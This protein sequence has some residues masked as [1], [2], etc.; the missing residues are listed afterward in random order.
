M[1]NYPRVRYLTEKLVNK[2]VEVW[3]TY[4]E[5]WLIHESEQRY[6]KPAIYDSEHLN[7]VTGCSEFSSFE[8]QLNILKGGYHEVGSTYGYL[9]KNVYLVNGYLYSG[10]A[11]YSLTNEREKFFLGSSSSSNT[12]SQGSLTSTYWGNRFFGD[13]IVD[14]LPQQELCAEYAKP[15]SSGDIFTPTKSFLRTFS[16]IEPIPVKHSKVNELYIFQDFAHN[17]SKIRRL[18][19]IRNQIK[20]SFASK[21]RN[22]K[23]MYLRGS[24]GA[25]RILENEAEIAEKLSNRGFTIIDPNALTPEQVVE[26]SIGADCIVSVDG[27]Q[28]MYSLLT[29]N[30]GCTVVSIQPPFRLSAMIKNFFEDINATYAMLVGEQK[31]EKSFTANFDEIDRALDRSA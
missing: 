25:T 1:F 9:L 30:E 8:D 10:S 3:D 12:L 20:S 2:P 23:I 19:N 17:A 11:K 28:M 18:F 15:I 7:R 14:S 21:R 26:K 13:W 6:F 4:S 16:G 22:S 31:G 24:S 5:R 29:A 27:S